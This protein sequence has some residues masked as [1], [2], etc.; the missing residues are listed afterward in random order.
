MGG[1]T[2]LPPGALDRA[3]HASTWIGAR[4][5]IREVG[6]GLSLYRIE[7]DDGRVWSG[8]AG[9]VEG[10][11]SD[12]SYLPD[13]GVG[14][15][16]QINA[17][18]GGAMREIGK[19]MRGT[20]ATLSLRRDAA[21]GRAHAIEGAADGTSY[22]RIG[23]ATAVT[24]LAAVALWVTSLI[25]SLLVALWGVLRWVVRRVRRRSGAPE[26][27]SAAGAALWR[28]S[29]AATGIMALFLVGLT[30]GFQD[31]HAL[32]TVSALSIL[33]FATPIAFAG[34][35]VAGTVLMT[36]TRAPMADRRQHV[37]LWL[38]RSATCLHP[39]TAACLARHHV[40]G[41]RPWA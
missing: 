12:L 20:V 5:G 23:T 16:V 33:V 36:K 24:T 1:D 8:H 2:L 9:G 22:E 38:A 34:C 10:G 27:V 39:L 6:Y 35:A 3:E 30:R 32:G 41:W 14:Y 21:D 4:R 31:V 28:L 7:G 40:I 19:A 29:I 25:V 11:I 37:S 18:H 15:A 26:K 17:A 13:E